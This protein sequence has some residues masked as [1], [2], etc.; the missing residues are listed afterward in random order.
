M[1][2][3]TYRWR[4]GYRRTGL[5]IFNPDSVLIHHCTVQSMRPKSKGMNH[6]M[7][8]IVFG[9]CEEKH[10]YSVFTGALLL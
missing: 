7:G 6:R 2:L 3:G 10:S 9:D 4:F 1:G 5:E 8:C